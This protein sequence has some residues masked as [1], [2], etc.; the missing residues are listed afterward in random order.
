MC[1]DICHKQFCDVAWYVSVE[2][3]Q[4]L[5]KSYRQLRLD[6]LLTF[7][8][9]CLT[10]AEVAAC[11]PIIYPCAGDKR[12]IVSAKFIYEGWTGMAQVADAVR[13]WVLTPVGPRSLACG[14]VCNLPADPVIDALCD[15]G[16][17]CE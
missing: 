11:D 17:R 16:L 14:Q 12:T 4:N 7:F 13:I 3:I 9:I 5:W 6:E 15:K 1:I 10:S 2:E 8:H